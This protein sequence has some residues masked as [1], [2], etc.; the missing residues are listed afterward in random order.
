MEEQLHKWTSLASHYIGE[1]FD[2]CKPYLDMDYDG[3]H[4]MLRFVSTQLYLSC[5]FS[6]QS[7]LILLREGQEWDANIINRSII[8]GVVKYVYMLQGS[9]EEKL[10]K[11]K[12][13]WEILP[14]YAA[15]KRSDR[16]H[17]FL[18]SADG[19]GAPE[20]RPIEDLALDDSKID[21]LRRGSNKKSRKQLEHSWSF[22]EILNSFAKGTDK[23]ML[24]L[25]HLAY[26]YGMSSHLVHKDGDG[27][28]MVWERCTRDI[29]RQNSVKLG[30]IA[31]SISDICTF[32]DMRSLFLMET[33]NQDK[34]FIEDLKESYAELFDSIE[35][36]VEY[37][38]KTE[39]S[40]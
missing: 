19:Y 1:H 21:T 34:S 5:H 40:K 24:P 15:V 37:F 11:V 9:D 7:S 22:T 17:R 23:R 27:V 36:S 35:R 10:N 16:A 4:P 2:H 32:A 20:W 26:N 33:C 13:Y 12:E 8:E 25:T 29:E 31:R 28:G 30:H 14:D 3:L 39:Y 6:S 38:N 18:S